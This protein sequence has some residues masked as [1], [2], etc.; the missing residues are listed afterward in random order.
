MNINSTLN[1]HGRFG[2]HFFR[3]LAFHF[4]AKN[5]NLKF[6]YSYPDKFSQL[7]I[8]LYKDG[9]NQYND[10]IDIDDSNFFDFIKND[11][12]FNK[13]ISIKDMYAQTSEF[14]TYIKNYIH[15]DEQKN[16]IIE[17]NIFKN[18]YNNNNDVFLHIRMGDS[19]DKNPGFIYYDSILDKLSFDNGYISSDLLSHPMCSALINKY[20]LKPVLIQ[21]VETIM[22]GSTCKYIVL[23]NGTFSWMIGLL[24][25]YSSIY[26]PKVK[27]KWHGDIFV[28]SEWNEIDASTSVSPFP[29]HIALKFKQKYGTKY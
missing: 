12:K 17:N 3:N 14:S 23:S 5:N 20:K 7:G 9:T 28:F 6:T 10:K 24:A 8:S 29:Y 27:N 16:K 26:Y 11:V 19:I 1:T 21:E 13:N 15:E 18:R 25:F 22:F 4:I 2:N